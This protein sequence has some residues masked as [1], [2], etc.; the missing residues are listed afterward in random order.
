[1]FSTLDHRPTG[2]GLGV[3]PRPLQKKRTIPNGWCV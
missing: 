2:Q 3:K 1:M